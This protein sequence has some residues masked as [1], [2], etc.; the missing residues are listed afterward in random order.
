LILAVD[1]VVIGSS[2]RVNADG[3]NEGFISELT[4]SP[5]DAGMIAIANSVFVIECI[6]VGLPGQS[7]PA[8]LITINTGNGF[9]QIL[10]ILAATAQRL[11]SDSFDADQADLSSVKH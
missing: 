5:E 8:R 10:G 9:E 1:A 7:F 6:L 3:A 11:R 4:S 2:V